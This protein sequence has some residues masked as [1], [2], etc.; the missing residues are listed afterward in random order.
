MH[1]SGLADDFNKQGEICRQQ[2]GLRFAYHN[3]GYT[4]DRSWKDRSHKI[5]MMENTD[6]DLV[7]FEMDTYWVYTAGK[8]P[9]CLYKKIPEQIFT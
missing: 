3:H 8:D 9:D 6:L 5:I 4:F 1:S 2:H 7:D